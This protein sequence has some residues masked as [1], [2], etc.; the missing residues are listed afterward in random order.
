MLRV[1]HELWT[2]GAGLQIR[3]A[4]QRA[5]AGVS[6]FYIALQFFGRVNLPVVEH[7]D[8]LVIFSCIHVP[9]VP[10]DIFCGELHGQYRS[11][12]LVLMRGRTLNLFIVNIS[13]CAIG[14]AFN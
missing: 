10:P 4:K 3:R 9:G 2:E 11:T 1:L 12:A 7:V 13:M 14:N 6:M 8:G 5:H